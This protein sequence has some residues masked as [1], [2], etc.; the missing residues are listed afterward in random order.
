[1]H[2]SDFS[3]ENFIMDEKFQEWVKY[4]IIENNF[5]WENWLRQNPHKEK[6]V[7]QARLIILSLDFKKSAGKDI[8]KELLLKKI[9]SSIYE[10][11][12][13]NSPSNRRNLNFYYKIAAVFIGLLVS[14]VSLFLLINQPHE[15]FTTTY[16]EIKNITLPDGSS[17]VLNANSSV[18]FNSIW[19]SGEDREVWLHG[20]AFFNISHKNDNQKFLVRTDQLNVEVLGTRFN[21]NTRRNNTKVVLNSGKV[22]LNPKDQLDDEIYMDPGELVEFSGADK[23]ITKKVVNPDHFSSWKTNQ[24]IFKATPL[25]EVAQT[26]E[27]NY[28]WTVEFEDEIIKTYQFTGTVSTGSKENINILLFTISEVFNIEILEENN[29][30]IFKYKK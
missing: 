30:M 23:K 10:E 19:D 1:M 13:I 14:T 15:K 3:I 21:V 20:E 7:R 6:E 29:Q 8:P 22:K 24:L 2:Y 25:S 28:G 5:F 11:D 26:L 4:P 12:L 9:Q 16:G 18:Q 17:I 27:D